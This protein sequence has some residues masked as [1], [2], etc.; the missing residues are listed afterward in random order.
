[1]QKC[2][3]LTILGLCMVGFTAASEAQS[4]II[5]DAA[6]KP[7]QVAEGQGFWDT[8]KEVAG[9]TW[10]GTKEI[11]SDVWDGTKKV[12]GDIWDGTKNMAKDIKDGVTED[13]HTSPDEKPHDT[14]QTHQK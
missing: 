13:D 2:L 5:I 3:F 11:T 8:T 10:D 7:L 14:T 4:Y 9:D 12:T 6:Q 1:M